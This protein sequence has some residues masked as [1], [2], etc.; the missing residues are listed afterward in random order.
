MRNR[1]I[2][3]LLAVTA[4]ATL[5]SASTAISNDET[6]PSGHGDITDGQPGENRTPEWRDVLHGN[7]IDGPSV[8]STDG[9]DD[10]EP[11]SN[12]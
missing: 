1:M 6:P 10:A 12:N 7:N 9:R 3:K 8:T 2:R 4:I 11:G 5:F